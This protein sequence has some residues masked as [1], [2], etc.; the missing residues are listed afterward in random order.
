MYN[1][2]PASFA[3]HDL[4]KNHGG[5]MERRYFVNTLIQFNPKYFPGSKVNKNEPFLEYPEDASVNKERVASLYRN[6][7]A[8][9]LTEKFGEM[10]ETKERAKLWADVMKK[11]I[12]SVV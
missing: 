1:S 8:R 3:F 6:K 11:G 4:V 2:N 5:A 12:H 10:P 9:D 7:L